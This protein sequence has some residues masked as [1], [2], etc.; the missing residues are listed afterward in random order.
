MI[1]LRVDE[2]KEADPLWFEVILGR[3]FTRNR[4]EPILNVVFVALHKLL[5]EGVGTVVYNLSTQ[6]GI[7]IKGC[8]MIF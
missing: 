4:T 7:Q 5:L 2:A 6:R 1:S 8:N 3:D